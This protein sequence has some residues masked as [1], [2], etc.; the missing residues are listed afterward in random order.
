MENTQKLCEMLNISQFKY[1]PYRVEWVEWG[2]QSN[3]IKLADKCNIQPSLVTLPADLRGKLSSDDWNSLIASRLFY[4]YKRG[5]G[6]AREIFEKAVLPAAGLFLTLVIP[7]WIVFGSWF[8]GIL[9]NCRAE[10][11]GILFFPAYLPAAVFAFI[12][13][14]PT[15][16]KAR[17]RADRMASQFVGRETMLGVLRK[18][19]L[20][21]VKSVEA[22]RSRS[23][24]SF[25]P[26]LKERIENVSMSLPNN[27]R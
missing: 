25:E 11:C 10:G 18:V 6:L 17:L 22:L 19:E 9:S 12:L 21:D 27:A 23:R 3:Q 16:R 1:N 2:K 5:K 26:S 24:L 13:A 8:G 15:V 4:S 7:Y 20:I 14:S